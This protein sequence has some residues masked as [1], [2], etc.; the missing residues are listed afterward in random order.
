[1]TSSEILKELGRIVADCDAA[2]RCQARGHDATVEMWLDQISQRAAD[3]FA[4]IAKEQP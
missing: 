4:R 2:K 1:M 3:T